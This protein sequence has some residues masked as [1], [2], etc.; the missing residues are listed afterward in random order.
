MKKQLLSLLLLALVA[1]ANA[2][3]SGYKDAIGVKYFP[4]S[5]SYKHFVNDKNAVEGLFYLWTYGVRATGLY[6]FYNPLKGFDLD[7]LNWYW[8]VGAHAHFWNNHWSTIYPGRSSS[9]SIGVDAVLG[10][11]FKVPNIPLN[12][13]IDWQPSL[14]LTGY[15]GG[16][17]GWGGVGIRYVLK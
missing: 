6:Q 10:V 5:L 14:N 3:I 2:Q 17:W 4:T 1:V 7:N 11:D 8:G 12:V 16:F 13:S 9:A 15:T